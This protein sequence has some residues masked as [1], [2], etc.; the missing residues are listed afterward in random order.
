MR[1]ENRVANVSAK[2]F[3]T[4]SDARLFKVIIEPA[5]Q[6]ILCWEGG[7]I[8]AANDVQLGVLSQIHVTEQAVLDYLPQKPVNQRHLEKYKGEGL[9]QRA[10]ANLSLGQV[11]GS[12]VHDVAAYSPRTV[13]AVTK[14][15]EDSERLAL[16]IL[17]LEC[18]L[19]L[20][21]HIRHAVI[22]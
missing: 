7:Q 14:V 2:V 10:I 16:F 1:I 17:E 3:R 19:G 5:Q 6:E 4:Q 8:F 20:I 12:Q 21:H 9:R 22:D 11:N 18:D 15:F 13:Q